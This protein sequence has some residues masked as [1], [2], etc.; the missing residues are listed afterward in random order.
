MSYIFEHFQM[1][2][3]ILLGAIGVALFVMYKPRGK[4]KNKQLFKS[5]VQG[6]N[7]T[8]HSLRT[9][10]NKTLANQTPNDQTPEETVVDAIEEAKIYIAYGLNDQAV[11]ALDDYLKL[12]PGD[13]RAL[14]LLEQATES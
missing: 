1:H 12:N 7:N 14:A 3:L 11:S 6:F 8:K 13:K 10:A 9:S 5:E 4:R 2:H